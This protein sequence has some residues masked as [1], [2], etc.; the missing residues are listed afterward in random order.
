MLRPLHIVT[1]FVHKS[2][3]N[4]YFKRNTRTLPGTYQNRNQER[5]TVTFPSTSTKRWIEDGHL[6]STSISITRPQCLETYL[7][8]KYKKNNSGL[9][10]ARRKFQVVLQFRHREKHPRK[11]L[12]PTRKNRKLPA[13]TLLHKR[14]G[15]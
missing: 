4:S 6:N 5:M 12:Q 9:V 3:V 2:D 1:L 13:W 15:G 8:S 7:T 14:K 11:V 10:V